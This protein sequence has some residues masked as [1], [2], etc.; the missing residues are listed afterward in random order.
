[1]LS[2]GNLNRSKLYFQLSDQLNFC[3]TDAKVLFSADLYGFQFYYDVVITRHK[4][5]KNGTSGEL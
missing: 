2:I 5:V 1:M 3:R 4:W